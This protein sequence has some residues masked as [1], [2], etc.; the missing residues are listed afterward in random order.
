MPSQKELKK[1]FKYDKQTGLL[2]SKLKRGKLSVNQIVGAVS[3]KGYVLVGLGNR[4]YKNAHRII[5][6]MAYGD[7]PSGMVI[8]HIN[9]VKTDNR[10]CNLRLVSRALNQR[11]S[12]L[13]V[14][15]KSGVMGVYWDSYYQK[16]H[17]AITLLHKSKHIGYFRDFDDAV[18]ARKEAEILHG[19]HA[20]H[21]QVAQL[22]N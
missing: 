2:R 6:T 10:L 18:R 9:H 22:L 1:L 13:F 12:K 21:G 4:C 7:I 14:T 20:N 5:W 3:G 8:D 11:N 19:F 15:N 16:W 17:A